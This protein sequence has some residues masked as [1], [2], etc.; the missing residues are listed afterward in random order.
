MEIAR[1]IREEIENHVDDA[2][3]M[4]YGRIADHGMD[5]IES[6]IAAELTPIRLTI[7]EIEEEYLFEISAST[8][9][10]LDGIINELS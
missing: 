7:E 4:F 5:I 9:E 6:I 10:E 3:F 8:V 1:R 2:G